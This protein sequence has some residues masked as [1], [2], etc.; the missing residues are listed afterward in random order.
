M[1]KID[2]EDVEILIK[3]PTWVVERWDYVVAKAEFISNFFSE[4]YQSIYATLI[5]N[6]RNSFFVILS[7]ILFW[8]FYAYCF[9][10]VTSASTWIIWLF[11]SVLVGIIQMNF[12]AYQFFMIAVDIFALTTLKT[13]KVIMQSRA[14][15]FVFFF[16]KQIKNSREKMWRRRSWRKQ[17]ASVKNYS[18]YLK[19]PVWEKSSSLR[20]AEAM[21]ISSEEDAPSTHDC[22]SEQ[23]ALRRSKSFSTMKLLKEAQAIARE[24]KSE[25]TDSEPGSP[26]LSPSR[27]S[28]HHRHHS[29]SQLKALQDEADEIHH[30]KNYADIEQDL[31]HS[32]AD[33]L[34]STTS[35]LKEERK[36]LQQG[37]DSGLEFLLSGVVKRNHLGLENLLTSNARDVEVSGQHGFSAATR[38]VIAAYY[39]EV[40][41]GLELLTD[42]DEK[43]DD[44]SNH[45]RRSATASKL[46]ERIFLFRKMKQNMGR[47]ALMLSGGGAQ[48]MYHLGTMR[49]L[50]DANLYHKIK[51]ISGTSGGSIAAA[52][53]A[54]F[55]PEEIEKDILLSTVSTD[56]R[57]SGEMKRQNIR[58]FPP[59]ADMISYWMKHRILIDSEVRRT[60]R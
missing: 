6:Q 41:R 11:A 24:F 52:C 15:Q 60:K 39:D 23:P 4:Q 5:V 16:S 9:V 44:D 49:A 22:P 7:M 32:T 21:A 51:V 54:M 55:T 57:L 27:L 48:A 3:V 38:K 59:V 43:D 40:S 28:L 35:R 10:A 19:L 12:V 18:E 31:G 58:W 13:Y 50:I 25:E 42:E 30:T 56:F 2:P 37:Q 45:M 1:D 46:R 26:P 8:P 53:C 33:L 17:C 20:V 29:L 14:A 34:I 36:K 47:T